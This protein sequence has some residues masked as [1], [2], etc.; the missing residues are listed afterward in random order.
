V[1]NH[2][3]PPWVRRELISLKAWSPE[4]GCR[5]IAEVF[6]RQF[7]ERGVSVGKT[8]VADVLRRSRS[9]IARLRR[10]LKHRVPMVATWTKIEVSGCVVER[11]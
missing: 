6:N 10:T 4:L 8:H 3:K 7:A 11:L 9:D 5:M 1:R 2:P